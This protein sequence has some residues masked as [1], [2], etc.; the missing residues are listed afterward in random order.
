MQNNNLQN[1]DVLKELEDILNTAK[2]EIKITNEENKV[3]SSSFF[4]NDEINIKPND[5]Y[6]QETNVDLELDN[7]QTEIFNPVEYNPEEII[8]ENKLKT[9]KKRSFFSPVIFLAKYVLTS[10]LLFMVLLVTTNY[11]AYINIAK[12]YIFA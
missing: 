7:H 3:D 10:S 8:Q 9:G 4:V 11:S 5:I 1:N 2:Q 6:E 12:S